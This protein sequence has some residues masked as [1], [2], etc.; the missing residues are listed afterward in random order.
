[1]V[2]LK[3]FFSAVWDTSYKFQ[4]ENPFHPIF[5]VTKYNKTFSSLLIKHLNV[6]ESDIIEGII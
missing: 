5:S 6:I 3:V 2:A 4:V 1:M